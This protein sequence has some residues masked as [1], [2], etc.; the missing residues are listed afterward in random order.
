[1]RGYAGKEIEDDAFFNSTDSV[2][3]CRT[4]DSVGSQVVELYRRRLPDTHRDPRFDALLAACPVGCK[5]FG[6]D[7]KSDELEKARFT[8]PSNWEDGIDPGPPT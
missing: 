1:M 2:D 7:E 8:N 4:D 6:S 5:R 3:S